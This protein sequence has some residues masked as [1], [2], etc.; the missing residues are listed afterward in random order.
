[1]K[2]II[3][4]GG[5]YKKFETPKQ[6][7]KINGEVIVERTIRLLKENGIKDIYVSTNNPAFDY[8]DVP[9]LKDKDNQFEY[10]G[11]YE[12]KKSKKCWLKAYYPMYE[13]VCYL[14]G[15]VYFSDEAIKTI[16]ETKVKDTMF[17][18]A[19]D[20]Q[21]GYKHYMSSG[22]R[23][24]FAYKVE[25]YK[26]F[27]DAVDS[28]LQM[29]D[30]GDFKGFPPCAWNVYRYINGL[31]I[32]LN[33]KW[34]GDLNSIFNSKGDYIVIN[35]YT[36]DVDDIKDVKK[37]EEKLKLGGGIMVKMEIINQNCTIREFNRLFNI[38]RLSFDI[39][40][41]ENYL[42]IGDTFECDE[43]MAKYLSGETPEQTLKIARVLEI[44]PAKIEENKTAKTT[45][46]TKVTKTKTVKK[47][48]KLTKKRK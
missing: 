43:E 10:W 27:R 26:L 42:K 16:V 33:A 9:K 17:F 24:P 4:C 18:C 29:I 38:K 21:D 34:Y 7:L 44:I 47:D 23:E 8:L 6:L 32:G 2:Y 36:N 37:I 31:D 25:N 13:P 39:G 40:Q 14:H 20:K 1:M 3:M 46:T 30:N 48:S 22:G 12:G 41:P 15:D 28:L 19:W 35:D 5:N 11:K 45:K